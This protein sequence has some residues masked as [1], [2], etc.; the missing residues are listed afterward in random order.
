MKKQQSKVL[1]K[2][3][4]IAQ[5]ESRRKADFERLLSETSKKYK[6]VFEALA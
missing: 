3:E 6:Q 4:Q 2:G 1:K 5:K